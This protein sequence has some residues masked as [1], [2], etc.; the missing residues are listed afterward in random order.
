MDLRAWAFK[1]PAG[2][3]AALRIVDERSGTL[4]RFLNPHGG[5]VPRVRMRV[6]LI[7][8]R[9]VSV[10]FMHASGFML[11]MGLSSCMAFERNPGD[12]ALEM[13]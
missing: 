11:V 5:V 1:L 2:A 10:K 12:L 8:R 7:R 3:R 6:I 4:E 9:N 13:N